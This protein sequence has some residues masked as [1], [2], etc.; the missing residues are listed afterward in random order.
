MSLQHF[1]AFLFKQ[2]EISLRL[3]NTVYKKL[4]HHLANSKLNG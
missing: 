4:K 2:F 3:L 1:D